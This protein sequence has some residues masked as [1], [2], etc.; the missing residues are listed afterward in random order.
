MADWKDRGRSAAEGL[1]GEFDR[2]QD[3]F[4]ALRERL[5]RLAG[6][7]MKDFDISPRTLARLR[8]AIDE[9]ISGLEGDLE[10]LGRELK[11]RGG[12][13][14]GRVERMVHEQPMT[15]LAIA[16]GVGFFAAHL[17]RRRRRREP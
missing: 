14:A 6:E 15:A 2:I 8:A 9:R 10:G 3:E 1:S 17:L 11:R 4:D 13:T 12:K 7:T 5:A 16:A